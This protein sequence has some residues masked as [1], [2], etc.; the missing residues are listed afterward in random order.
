MLPEEI[1]NLSASETEIILP[2][3]QALEAI[4]Y[5]RRNNIVCFGWELI[6]RYPDGNIGHPGE[7]IGFDAE[8]EL[9]EAFSEFVESAAI[10]CSRSI[11][12]TFKEL[13]KIYKKKA[14]QLLFCII[15]SN[16]P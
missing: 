16:Q 10:E 13:E 14:I 6:L 8:M 11:N 4:E 7:V 1:K 9:N 12:E 5:W 2:Y 15:P 3:Q